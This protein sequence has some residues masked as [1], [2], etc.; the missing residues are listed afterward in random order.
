MAKSAAKKPV[1]QAAPRPAV[2]GIV[3]DLRQRSGMTLS[4]LAL[5][6]GVATSTISK[7]EAGQLSPGYEII[8]KL[9]HGLQVDVAELFRPSG[10]TVP[11]ARRGITRNGEGVIHDTEGYVYEALANE[12]ARKEFIPLR[13]RVKARERLDWEELPAHEGEEFVFVMSGAIRLFT[14][15]YEPLDLAPGDSVYFDSRAGH[16]LISTSDEDADILWVCSHREA[17]ERVQTA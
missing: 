17:I 9:A 13:V 6:S 1:R 14:E 3:K 10:A 16:A 4:E 5:Q 12:V 15:H 11:T 7:I 8:V 2:A